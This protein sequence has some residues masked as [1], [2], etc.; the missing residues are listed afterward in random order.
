MLYYG[1]GGACSTHGK[2]NEYIKNIT[3]YICKDHLKAYT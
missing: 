2:D 3:P 1:I